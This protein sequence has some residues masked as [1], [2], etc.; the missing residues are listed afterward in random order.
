MKIKWKI[1]L[2]TVG[3]IVLLTAAIMNFTHAEINSLVM[4]KN[5]VELGN[6]SHMGL[7]L[8]NKSYDGNWSI[9]DNKLY[10]GE[11][12][13]NDNFDVID[14]FTNGTNIL[15]T[16][17][18]Q[19]TRI[20]T[21][22]MDDNGKRQVGT[23]AS[24][25]VIQ[26]VLKQGK[27][28]TGTADILGKSAQ[29]FYVPIKDNGGTIIGM[30]F[31]GI[32]TNVISEQIDHTMM[33]IALLAFGLLV[34]SSMFSYF[35]GSR[36]ARGVSM[37]QMKL[38]LMEEGKF[39]F[40]FTSEL[41]NRKDEIGAIATSSDHMKHKIT[42]ILKGIRS[43]SETLKQISQ[44]SFVDMEVVHGNIEDI[45]ATTEELSAGMEE[46]SA[47]TEEMNASTYDIETEVA[48]MKEKT[49]SGETL[50]AKIKQRAFELKGETSASYQN[51]TAMYER[52]NLQLRDSIMKTAVISEIKELSQTI[53]QITAQ[54][55]LLALN[56]SIE[57]ARAGE[58]GKGFSVVA[59][60]IRVL[61]D[62][63]RAAVSRINEITYHVSEAVEGLVQ[64]SKALL[65]FVDTQVI[66]DYEMFV[67]T[68]NQYELDSSQVQDVVAEINAIAEQ[69]FETMQQM[70]RVI[71]EIT[72]AAGEGA[73]G[74]SDIANKV[75]E[76]ASK[77]DD[78]LKL[79][80]ENRKSAD[81]LDQMI[82]FF[83]L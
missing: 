24:E 52:T 27:E 37:I 12:L 83:K 78:V 56:A 67:K 32:Y 17:F 45:S 49:L 35:I 70:R 18:Y 1:V 13:I 80:M 23:K 60:E 77:S 16:I 81:E 64:D 61:A 15:A 74:I 25:E 75:S 40:Q 22:V 53:L 71:D 47:S 4:S 79:N 41:L 26:R 69:L 9:K 66:K 39:N 59:D 8:I 73:D 38:K 3:T 11:T 63:S 14:E 7:D 48:H 72:T 42:D 68:S 2:S 57:A 54:T 5:T 36:I 20:A 10:K 21:N 29:T 50:A 65:E 6:Y 30:W 33:M 55:N 28:Y 76:I 19:D 58:A 46:T 43:E 31:I 51:A 82:G 44:R 34:L 62:N